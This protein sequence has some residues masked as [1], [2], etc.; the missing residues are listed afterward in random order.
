VLL[1]SLYLMA[2]CAERAG[3]YDTAE[4]GFNTILALVLELYDS[5]VVHIPAPFYISKYLLCGPHRTI[6]ILLHP[7][8]WN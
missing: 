3:R 2:L 1:G 4:T 5:Q 6:Q 8:N 7:L